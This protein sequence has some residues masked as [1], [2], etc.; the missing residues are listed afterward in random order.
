MIYDAMQVSLISTL[1][2][3]TSFFFLIKDG[4]LEETLSCYVVSV[5]RVLYVYLGVAIR[6]QG[7]ACIYRVA[8]HMVTH[9]RSHLMFLTIQKGG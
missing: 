7:V 9:S 8:S 5:L 3:P 6:I 2:T 4:I 1:T